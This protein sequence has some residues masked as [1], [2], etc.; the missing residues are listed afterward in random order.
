MLYIYSNL[1]NIIYFLQ[2]I[3][4]FVKKGEDINDKNVGFFMI[5]AGFDGSGLCTFS[6]MSPSLYPT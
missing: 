6:A 5:H 3:Y 2:L 1:V 4:K